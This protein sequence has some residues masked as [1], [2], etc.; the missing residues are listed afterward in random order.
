MAKLTLKVGTTS[1]RV[2]VFIQDSSVTTGAGK[3]GLAYNTSGIKWYVAREDDG[4][5]GGTAYTPAPATLGTWTSIGFKEKDATNMPGVYELGLH[6]AML[7]S[8]SK[9][10]SLMISGMTNAA[11]CLVEIE[12]VAYD[13]FDAV[14]LGLSSLPN[15]AVTTN[16]SLLTSGTGTDQLSVTSGQVNLGKILGTT[17]STPATAGIL[18]V[19]VKNINN[20]AAATP[21]AS[22]G[23]LI[24]GVNSG[25][26]TVGAL[27]ITGAMSINGTGNVSQTGDSYTRLGAPAG[28]SIAADLAEIE[29]ETDGISAIPTTTPLTAAQIATGIWQDTVSS[30]FTLAASVGLS[31]M[32]GVALG[33]GLKI[34]SYTGNTPQTGD[35]FLR[36]G[37]PAGASVSA[38][39][40]EIEGETDSI[41]TSTSGL[42]FTVA[43]QVDSNVITK[44]G[45]GLA[46]SGLDSVLVSDLAGVPTLTAK[47][48]DAIAFL[49]MGLRNLRTTTASQDKVSNDSGSTIGTATVSD[50]GTT[51]TKNKYS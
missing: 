22:G 12:L 32:N 44:T 5:A 23:I 6:N 20:T 37:A 48:V 42:T 15:T 35:A 49:Y 4:N 43:N 40:A 34:N 11:P 51:F 3:T 19:N 1:Q 25:T 38:D 9:Y 28:A 36:L 17:V 2:F 21:G 29:A 18:D 41:Q 33:T 24:S 27:T 46:S 30:D 8:G 39:I 10:C 31:I 7:A 14:H 47:I 45:F 50:D 13:P 16:G 26:T